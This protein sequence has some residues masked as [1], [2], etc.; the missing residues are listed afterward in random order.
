MCAAWCDATLTIPN[1]NFG[2]QIIWTNS[3]IKVNNVTIY[4]RRFHQAGVIY[5]KDLFNE[6]GTIVNYD[7]F[8]DKFE[9][10]QFPFTL[11]SGIISAN[12]I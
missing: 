1:S 4:Y 2:E 3:L 8:M 10:N 9:L 12:S 5:V 6:D 7:Q 11:L